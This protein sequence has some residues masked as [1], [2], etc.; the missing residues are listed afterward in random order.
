MGIQN[1][2]TFGDFTRNIDP[3][4]AKWMQR[5][6]ETQPSSSKRPTIEEPMAKEHIKR[7]KAVLSQ[8]EIAQAW[9]EQEKG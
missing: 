9:V 2:K 7:L 5:L 3:E 8:E 1:I 6:L 4:Y